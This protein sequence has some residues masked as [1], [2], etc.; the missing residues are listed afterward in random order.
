MS[1]PHTKGPVDRALL[2]AAMLGRIAA[3]VLPP[4]DQA[5]C[6]V[7]GR[8]RERAEVHDVLV[9]AGKELLEAFDNTER[10]AHERACYLQLAVA[11]IRDAIAKA[12]GSP[13]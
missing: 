7:A 12:T 2:D 4:H 5:L 8:M 10:S 6:A 11:S 13:A 1:V 3:A 9:A